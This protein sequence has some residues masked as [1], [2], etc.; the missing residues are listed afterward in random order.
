MAWNVTNGFAYA[1][2][3]GQIGAPNTISFW[4][5]WGVGDG[6]IMMIGG[7]GNPCNG[8]DHGIGVTEAASASFQSGVFEDDFGV[9]GDDSANNDSY[10]LN[11]FVR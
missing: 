10:A 2:C 6:A 1:M 8:A 4:A 11:L 9:E 3:N 7:G 5:D